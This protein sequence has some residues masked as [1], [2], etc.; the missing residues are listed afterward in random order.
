MNWKGVLIAALLIIPLTSCF[1]G[2]DD[3]GVDQAQ[4]DAEA[5]DPDAQVKLG[6]MYFAGEGVP[7]DRAE[8]A[9]WMRLAAEQGHADAQNYLGIF[10]KWG[11]GVAEN[12]A[13]A[14]KWFRLAAEQGH[15]DAQNNH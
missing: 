1:E 2:S 4:P 6:L 12:D 9:K 11:T 3:K 8:A 13:E 10:N 5:G 14:T 7:R 15:A